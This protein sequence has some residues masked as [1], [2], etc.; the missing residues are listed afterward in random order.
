MA[1]G[2][3]EKIAFAADLYCPALMI[4]QQKGCSWELIVAQAIQETGWG[5]K[6]LPGTNNLYNIK[7]KEGWDGPKKTARV[8]EEVNGKKQWIDDDFRVYA[9]Y[10]ES[11]EDR[12]AFL[13][14]NPRYAVLNEPGVKGNYK[15]EA[16]KIKEAGFATDSNYTTALIRIIEGPSFKKAMKMAQDRGCGPVL[17]AID[18]QVLDGARIPIP[19][20]K[21]EIELDGKKREIVTSAKGRFVVR[22][23]LQCGDLRVRVY[24]IS[25]NKWISLEPLSC[26][27]APQGQSVTLIAPTFTAQTSTREHDKAPSAKAAAKSAPFPAPGAAPAP[28][29][30]H[31]ET[32]SNG[33]AGAAP[34][35]GVKMHKVE[36]GESLALIASRNGV[37]YQAIAKLNGITSPFIIRPDQIL[38]I[39]DVK[40][41]S[42][43]QERGRRPAATS[44]PARP[45]AA[46]SNVPGKAPVGEDNALHT[47]YLRNAQAHPQT[48]LMH[49]SRAPWMV[50]AQ[51]EFEKGV[52]R[53][54]GSQHDPRILEYFKATPTLPKK[55]ASVDETAYCAAFANW[56]LGRVGFKGSNSARAASFRNWGRAT[57]GNRPALG[58]VA[59]IQ[60]EG[61]SYHVTFVA[62]ITR[63]GE[64]IA[65]LG[66]NQGKAHEVSHSHCPTDLVVAYRYP[67]D[68]PDYDDDYVLHDVASDHSPM[69]AAS[70]R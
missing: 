20:A 46:S 36:K 61:G 44:Q 15:E 3:T 37:R 59:L 34:A 52:R 22:H 27:T 62:G 1:Y 55:L 18:V 47:V 67:A 28:K 24:D 58:A 17:P 65:T 53:R 35:L 66:G 16:R 69:T 30:S 6:C 50:P 13:E 48:D 33:P 31:A 4:S 49:V 39:P 40:G 54:P 8:W 51:Q 32:R 29:A 14:K 21:I 25:Q 43:T 38:K 45:A 2:Y 7:A 60:F 64:S 70:T 57:R 56:C 41:A 42:A 10:K 9:S 12:M 19:E 63:D 68:Y 11:L 23:K 5:E 26:S